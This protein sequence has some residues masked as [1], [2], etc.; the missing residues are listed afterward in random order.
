[1]AMQ[2][3]NFVV[4]GLGS[5]RPE[6]EDDCIHLL[7]KACNQLSSFFADFNFSS[8]Y[9]SKPMYLENQDLFYNMVVC[10][11]LREDIKPESFL[12]KIHIIEASLGRDRSREIRNG[13]RSIDIDIEIFGTNIIHT[14]KLEIPHPRIKERDFVLLPMFDVLSKVDKELKNFCL[15]FIE[16][17]NAKKA[18]LSE[19][20]SD[21]VFLFMDSNEF[22][23]LIVFPN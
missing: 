19:M 18:K 14:E 5:N 12:D 9:R 13:P 8:I 10:G 3:S 1:M 21:V 23:K 2:P 16:L 11:F 7:K 4:L 20:K 6:K 15:E 17:D 22:E